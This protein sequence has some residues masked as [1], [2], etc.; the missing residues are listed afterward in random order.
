MCHNPNP[1]RQ[2][3]L[4]SL[5]GVIFV[6]IRLLGGKRRL[7]LSITHKLSTE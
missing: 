6:P 4:F 7:R 1:I 5:D 2:G 3:V